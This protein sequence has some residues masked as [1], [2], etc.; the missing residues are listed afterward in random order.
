MDFAPEPEHQMLLDLVE[1]FVR[2]ELLPLEPAVLA[3]EAEGRGA[4]IT[5]EERSRINARAR[6]LGLW[7]LD[8]PPEFGGVGLPA[9][10]IVGVDIALGRTVTPYYFQPDTPNLKMLDAV[11]SPEQRARYLEPYVK[12][13]L[14]SAIA[15]SEPSAGADPAAMKTTA[16]R[17]PGG[18]RL[19]GRKIWISRADE[20]DFTIVMAVSKRLGNGHAGMSAF[21][22][23]RG[24]PGMTVA[25]RIPMIGGGETFEVVFEDCD[26]PASA[27][28]GE[29]G[30]GFAPMQVRLGARRLEIC[31]WCIGIAERALEMM[32]SYAKQRV[33]FGQPLSDRQAVQWWI[34]DGL[35]R[36]KACRLMAYETA[37]R[38]DQGQDART[39]V[40]MLKVFATETAQKV[41][42]DAM[43]AFGAMGMTKELPLHLMAAQV[44]LMR[45]YDGPS[46][47][48]RWVVARDAL[49]AA[50]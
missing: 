1:R 6:E 37:W 33:T 34:A 4:H 18:W 14:T 36:V 26:L 3:R 17:T 23:D 15:I 12:D 30:A 38:L 29:E 48:H 10:A 8:A 2:D 42:D 5:A 44:R 47:V 11:A 45:I 9:Q 49:R 20:A 28:L 7:G 25:R 50:S 35:T 27:L 19:N 21:L 13:G 24:A 41:V 46:E 31:C 16:E 40:S 22:V 32:T 39:A 43:Q